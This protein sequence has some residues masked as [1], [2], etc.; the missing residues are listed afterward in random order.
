MTSK[1][2]IQNEEGLALVVALMLLVLMSVMGLAALS[3]STTELQLT[4]NERTDARAFH[5]AEAG[6]KEVLYRSTLASLGATTIANGGSVVTVDGI[7]FDAAI[8]N[9]LN[10]DWEYKIFAGPPP[11]S[12]NPNVIHSR[13]LMPADEAKKLKYTQDTTDPND[14]EV[15]SVRYVIEQDLLDWGVTAGATGVGADLNGDGDH[16]DLVFFDP[17]PGVMNRVGAVATAVE[18]DTTPPAHLNGNMAVRLV[19]A[20][21]YSGRGKKTIL[22]ET[23]GVPVNPNANAA[24]QTEIPITIGGSGFISG[25]NHSKNTT[26]DDEDN[27]DSSKYDNNGCDNFSQGVDGVPVGGCGN[28]VDPDIGEI[29]AYSGMLEGDHH[30]PGVLSSVADPADAV[31]QNGNSVEA[32]GGRDDDPPGSGTGWLETGAGAFPDLPTLLGVEPD[33]VDKIKKN[34]NTNPDSCPTGVTYIDNANS[35]IYRPDQNCDGGSGIL[36]VSGDMKIASNFEFRGLVYVEGDAELRGGSWLL[37]SMAVKGTTN[38]LQASNGTPTI[39][40]SRETVID[41]VT[42]A[43]NQIGFAFT[44]LSWREF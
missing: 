40:Y 44:T 27:V 16:D 9:T 37:G 2:I 13:M 26:K 6:I 22:L 5:A 4:S 21:G 36:I 43:F 28:A 7:T 34:A 33:I 23:T 10:A 38:G 42:A 29:A 25:Y 30:K 18:P 20:T 12:G 1:K 8:T 32:W 19:T 41:A 14:P 11:P 24:V 31:D 39:L 15:L 3:T 35:D 17:D